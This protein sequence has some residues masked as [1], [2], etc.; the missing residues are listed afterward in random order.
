MRV[1]KV[2]LVDLLVI[3]LIAFLSIVLSFLSVDIVYSIFEWVITGKSNITWRSVSQVLLMGCSI[4]SFI[5]IGC[6]IARWLG[7]KGF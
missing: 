6:V 3:F 7:L 5:G 1:R 4:G 2:K